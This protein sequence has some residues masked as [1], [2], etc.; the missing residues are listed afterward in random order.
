MREVE[1]TVTEAAQYFGRC[2]STIKYWCANGTFLAANCRV[3]R[4]KSGRWIIY[5]PQS[6]LASPITPLPRTA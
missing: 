1:M 2:Q 4:K 3:E 5:I 6:S